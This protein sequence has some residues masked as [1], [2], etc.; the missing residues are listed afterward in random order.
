M[1][2]SATGYRHREEHHR[3]CRLTRFQE[4]VQQNQGARAAA[5]CRVE[6]RRLGSLALM[7]DVVVG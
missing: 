5:F 6:N 3:A 2:F 7:I 1:I 4:I